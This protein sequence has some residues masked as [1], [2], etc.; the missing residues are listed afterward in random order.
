MLENAT[1]TF[2][3]KVIKKKKNYPPNRNGTRVVLNAGRAGRL[4]KKKTYRFRQ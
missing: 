4:L 3:A 1:V 2:V